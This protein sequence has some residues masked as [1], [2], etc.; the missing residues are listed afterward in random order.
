MSVSKFDEYLIP[1]K[2]ETVARLPKEL[3]GVVRGLVTN[4]NPH[5]VNVS[6]KE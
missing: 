4:E 6:K 1:L 3:V 2:R 5:P